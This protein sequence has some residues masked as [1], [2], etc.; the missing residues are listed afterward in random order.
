MKKY[1]DIGDLYREKFSDYSPQPPASVWEKLELA[2]QK[3]TSLWRKL[4]LPFAGIVLVGSVVYLFTTNFEPKESQTVTAYE[5]QNNADNQIVN[6]EKQD[7]S[8]LSEETNTPVLQ[9]QNQATVSPT[10][11]REQAD[12]AVNHSSHDNTAEENQTP[13][14]IATKASGEQNQKQI[15]EQNP[16]KTVQ[17]DVQQPQN[18]PVKISMDTTVCENTAAQLYIFNA[19]N[20]R[21]NTGETKNHIT[22]YPSYKEQYSVT[23][24]TKN[25]KDTT[26]YIHIDVVSCTEVY[27]PNIFT[28]NGD[29]RND[30][31]FV[32]T[33]MK[34]KSFE[35]VV[36]S[37]NGQ[38]L[39]LSKDINRGWDGTYKG[40]PQP[41]GLY[42]YTVR[43]IDNLGKNVEKRGELLLIL[44]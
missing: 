8:E 3:K 13:P 42:F 14:A 29:G 1:N 16:V 19:E 33:D 38:Q 12:L 26:V 20:I 35:M 43:Y 18:L 31:F 28:P 36:Y 5:K 32:E 40:Q 30:I 2:T 10:Q 37:S 23:F 17:N 41:H 22:V 21:W 11:H 34:L 15:Q 39:F 24:S 25:V 6:D 27:I 4:T 7:L 44:Q 9:Q